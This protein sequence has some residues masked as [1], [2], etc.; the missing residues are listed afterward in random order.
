M[1]RCCLKLGEKNCVTLSIPLSHTDSVSSGQCPSPEGS[2]MAPPLRKSLAAAFPEPFEP[3][4]SPSQKEKAFKNEINFAGVVWSRNQA[5]TCAIYKHCPLQPNQPKNNSKTKTKQEVYKK[6]IQDKSSILPGG[7]QG[8]WEKTSFIAVKGSV[9]LSS[10]NSYHVSL[11]FSLA[12]LSYFSSVLLSTI[13][14]KYL[15]R[16]KIKV[17]FYTKQKGYFQIVKYV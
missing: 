17:Q 9:L 12:S 10:Q 14:V 13:P 7:I 3:L 2:S 16:G 6:S 5:A 1:K 8:Y 4:L 15:R 11:F